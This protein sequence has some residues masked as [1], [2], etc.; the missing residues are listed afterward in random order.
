MITRPANMLEAIKTPENPFPGLRPFEFYESDL[1]FGRDGQVE[2]LI[3]K[4][5]ATRFL[6]VVG[7]SGSGKSSLV[8]A[9]L[10]PAL[11]GGMMT[12]AAS[13]WRFLI[14]R[15]GNDPIGNLAR[16][17]NEPEIFGSEDPES[18]AIQT[19]VAETTLRRGTRGL[20]EAVRQNGM[21]QTENLL[22]V[23]DQFEELFRF[24]REAARKAKDEGD[25]YQNEAAAFVK[26]LLE[27]HRQRE[28]NIFVVLTMRSD[29]LGDCA[30]FWDLPEAINESQYL[31]PRLTREQLRDVITGP[32]TLGA[33]D[34]TPRL[35]TQLLND[36]GDNQDQLPVLQH[37]LMRVWDEWKQKRLNVTVQENGKVVTKP[38]SEVHR[39]RAVDLCCY[40]AVGGMAEAL[41]R[42]ADAAFNEL[43]DDRHREVAEKVFKALTEKGP[44]NREIRRPITFA[45]LLAETGATPAE[46]AL[47]IEAFR[48]P[49]RSFLMPP[50]N[51]KLGPESLVDISHESL[52]RGWRRLLDWV[53]EEARSARTYQRL[54]A[55][56]ELNRAGAEGLLRDPGLQVALDWR[57]ANRPNAAWAQRYEPD[58]DSAMKYLEASVTARDAER[59][60][61]ERQARRDAKYKRSRI[62]IVFLLVASALLLGMFGYAYSK[63]LKADARLAAADQKRRDAEALGDKASADA[64]AATQQASDAQ[65]KMNEAIKK[66]E[67][68][69]KLRQSAEQESARAKHSQVVAED[70]TRQAEKAKS[71]AEAE[72]GVAVIAR[73]NAELL[74]AQALAERDSCE[75]QRKL[76]QT[77]LQTIQAQGQTIQAQKDE[78]KYKEAALTKITSNGAVE[79]KAGEGVDVSHH[80]GNVD[81]NT[82]AKSG[83]SFAFMKA[84]QGTNLADNMF[85]SNTQQA[86]AAGIPTGAYHFLTPNA[87]PRQQAEFF[88][89]SVGAETDLRPVLDVEPA[90]TGNWGSPQAVED[91]MRIWLHTVESKLGCKPIIFT[92]ASFA[93]SS[94]KSPEFKEYPLWIFQYTSKSEPDIPPPWS[95]WKL[96]QYTDSGKRAGIFVG[97]LS[98]LSGSIDDLRCRA[99]P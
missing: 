27:A 96:W 54:A 97:D 92:S 30:R 67:Q 20:I 86:R 32:V 74:K 19:A 39:G 22:V 11:M 91:S 36:I 40:Q 88:L 1:F 28:V 71:A 82:L 5:A 69:E 58:F 77:Q 63:N 45:E 38:H 34:I 51:I 49:G 59:Q 43:P 29:F 81:W 79:A 62:L 89:S 37:L 18:A 64:V 83:I 87:D 99:K 25:R 76:V 50:A 7:T 70:K 2:R 17:L 8:R 44:D 56:A 94:I 46:V 93:R 72:R 21:P 48:Q 73:Q 52:I 95:Q 61:R 24:A 42:H 55:T 15:P 14:M 23:V 66:S 9:G 12:D 41:S 90:V 80:N 16:A 31:I 98:R 68:A 4:L 84:T 75:Q 85:K 65:T 26:L 35:V 6:A 78:I 33:G 60:E 13:N 53:D 47:I 10:L 57:E 3:Q